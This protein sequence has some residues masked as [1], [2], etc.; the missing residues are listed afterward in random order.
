MAVFLL[1]GPEE[2]EKSEFIKREKNKIRS[3]YPDAEDYVFFGGDED[4]GIS[5]ALSQ[6]SLFSSYRFVV[7]K[8]YENVKKTDETYSALSDFGAS[9]QD[10]CTLIVTTTETSS[11][12]LPKSLVSVAGKE[13]TIVFWEMFDNEKR[14]WI[15]EFAS[16]EG[17]RI[18][19]DAIDEILSSVDN[20]TQEMK[21]LVGSITN[22]LKIQK[23]EDNTITLETIEAYSVRT[24][25]ENGYSLFRAIGEGNLEKALLSVSS[26]LLNDSRDIIPALS[27]L[28]T[29]FRRLEACIIMQ[30]ERKSEKEIFD[31]VTFVSPYPT[32]PGA[33]RNTGV[34]G[35]EKDLYRK[36]MR[37]YTLEDTRRIISLLGYYDTVLKSS[38]TDLL[39][40][41]AENLIYTI[42]VDKGR[43]TPLSLDPP[44]LE[45]H[46]FKS[47]AYEAPSPPQAVE[48]WLP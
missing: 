27:V 18:T 19:E 15:R 28:A 32:R 30:K 14:R 5:S 37:I 12:N 25:G 8:H 38:S 16:K 34:G 4:G 26:I 48:S 43:E 45:K 10:D 44:S 46:Y 35:R 40:L 13:N 2:G 1:L 21:N 20:N 39:K 41:Y 33:K 7:L 23:S 42:I 6:S 29:S 11:V 36:A 17:Y 3:L 31:T 47:S 9:P 24:K 22:F